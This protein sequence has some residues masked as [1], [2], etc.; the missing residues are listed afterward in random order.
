MCFV[1]IGKGGFVLEISV[2]VSF[3]G[4]FWSNFWVRWIVSY[5]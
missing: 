4:N 1:R 5:L 2:I 3:L